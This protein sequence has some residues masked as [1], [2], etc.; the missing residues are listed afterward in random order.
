M[1]G[2]VLSRV[3]EIEGERGGTLTV[4]S[5]EGSPDLDPARI[6]DVYGTMMRAPS[7]ARHTRS[8]LT[9][10]LARTPTSPRALRKSRTT[11]GG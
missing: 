5:L 10:G 11:A 4:V 8:G 1:T 2:A 9:V 7:T 3:D 6:N